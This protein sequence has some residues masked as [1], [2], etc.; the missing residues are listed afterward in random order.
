MHKKLLTNSL[1]SLLL[2]LAGIIIAFVVSP[3][4]VR[5][6]GNRDYGAWDLVSSIAGYLGVLDLGISPAII[7]LIARA[8]AT[9]DRMRMNKVLNSAIAILS[10]VGFVSMTIM[11]VLTQYCHQILNVKQ[12]EIPYLKVLFILMAANLLVNFPGTAFVAYLMG[13]IRYNFINGLRLATGCGQAIVSCYLLLTYPKD[14]LFYLILTLTVFNYLQY[15]II[16]IKVIISL[17][18][19]DLNIRFIDWPIIKELTRFGF[20]SMILMAADRIQRAFLPLVLAHT[21]G[22]G[23]IVFFSIPRML[24][25]YARGSAQALSQPLMPYYGYLDG[26]GDA[27][28]TRQQWY[29]LSKVMQFI[30]LGVSVCVLAFGEDFLGIWLGA[31]YAQK[32]KWVIYILGVSLL[33][34][35][36]GPNS[37]RYLIGSGKHGR[38]ARIQLALSSAMLGPIYFS[39]RLFGVN[40]VAAA[41]CVT[42]SAA[43]VIFLIMVCKSLG[44]SFGNHIART[45]VPLLYPAAA[46]ILSLLTLRFFFPFRDYFSITLAVMIA[47]AVYLIGGWMCLF[48]AHERI[49]VRQYCTAVLSRL[50]PVKPGPDD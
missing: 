23:Q 26:K 16:A 7:S 38:A 39:A 29:E 36:I 35:S 14:G 12:G 3:I 49:A 28:Q 45:F 25:E 41:L 6:L 50:F 4:M 33:I 32:G 21:T 27:G 40:G 43:T 24:I 5:T 15:C 46:L 19:G 1:T 47:G 34:D 48:S 9:N 31:L 11:L 37:A 8:S 17:Q 20:S 44:I 2:H 22:I 42:N 30:S 13:L 18:R 10:L